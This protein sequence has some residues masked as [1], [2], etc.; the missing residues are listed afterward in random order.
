LPF[1]R[2]IKTAAAAGNG[3]LI[4]RVFTLR[5]EYLN[6]M[7]R[8]SSVGREMGDRGSTPRSNT[9]ILVANRPPEYASH[10]ARFLSIYTCIFS[11]EKAVKE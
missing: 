11:K 9:I 3:D 8:N 7:S 4:V 5:P 2:N 6:V 10:S 1:G